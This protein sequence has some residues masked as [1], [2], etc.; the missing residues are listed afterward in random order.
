MKG[1]KGTLDIPLISMRYARCYLR[2]LEKNNKDGTSVLKK[3]GID[4]SWLDN[5]DAQL[6]VNHVLQLIR[7]GHLVSEDPSFAFRFGKTLDLHTHGLFGFALLGY[8][9]YR[10]F[11]KTV[12][13]YLRVSLPLV[14]MEIRCEGPHFIIELHENWDFGD[15][16][17]DVLSLYMGSIYTLAKPVCQAMA[18]EFSLPNDDNALDLHYVTEHCEFHFNSA[19]SRVR[20][21][22]LQRQNQEQFNPISGYVTAVANPEQLHGNDSLEIA[23]QVRNEITNNPGRDST[24]ERVAERLGMS[25]RSVRRHL[26]LAGCPFSHLRNTIREHF[27]SRYLLD[28]KLSLDQIAEK[29]GYSD[30]AS[31]TK[32]Y[33][34]WTGKTPGEV[35]RKRRSSQ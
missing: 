28:S 6:T 29:L 33:R 10:K 32:A 16:R 24:L 15:Y 17:R 9:D 5:P 3:S 20:L 21:T 13:E 25:A 23:R 34:S 19:S 11:T 35:R 22:F 1:D 8:Q 7:T 14:D 4:P 27:A 12:V 26:N 31:F 30:Q 2:F 18:F